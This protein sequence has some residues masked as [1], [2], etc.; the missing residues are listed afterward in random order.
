MDSL[1]PLSSADLEALFKEPAFPGGYQDLE[2]TAAWLLDPSPAGS[3][4][5]LLPAFRRLLSGVPAAAFSQG[6]LLLAGPFLPL[7]EVAV[8]A[9]MCTQKAMTA[10][11]AR[12]FHPLCRQ[13]AWVSPAAAPEQIKQSAAWAA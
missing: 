8:H 6:V 1:P 12:Q 9:A 2:E 11:S 4:P 10:W 5:P 3:Q 7:P 13:L